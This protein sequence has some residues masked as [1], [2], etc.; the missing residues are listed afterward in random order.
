MPGKFYEESGL[1]LYHQMANADHIPSDCA[2]VFTQPYDTSVIAGYLKRGGRAV[3]QDLPAISLTEMVPD[4]V[5]VGRMY[6]KQVGQ[7]G[8]YLHTHNCSLDLDLSRYECVEACF[9]QTKFCLDVIEQTTSPD[10]LVV[11]P[12]MGR[13]SVGWAARF[14]GRRFIGIDKQLVR[15]KMAKE[16]ICS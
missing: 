7:R 2:L 3:L 4:L 15:V 6:E 9:W 8:Q 10:D 12:F 16:F 14:S 13:G 11:D 1:V 5:R